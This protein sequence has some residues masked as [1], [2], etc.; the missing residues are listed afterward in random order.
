ME[1]R[2]RL[3]GFHFDD[4]LVLDQQVEPKARIQANPIIFDWK[5][6]LAPALERALMEFVR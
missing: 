3:D 4:T 1:A 5:C 2:K 6:D